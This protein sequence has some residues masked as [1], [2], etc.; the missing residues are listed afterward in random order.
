MHHAN[1]SSQQSQYHFQA[2]LLAYHR[3]LVEIPLESGCQKLTMSFW[4]WQK[5]ELQREQESG[6]TR[7]N[8]HTLSEDE[9]DFLTP[10]FLQFRQLQLVLPMTLVVGVIGKSEEKKQACNEM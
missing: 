10:C 9:R 6:L 5:E 8:D 3:T 1:L 7:M 4:L 2:V